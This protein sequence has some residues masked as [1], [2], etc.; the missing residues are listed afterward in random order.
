LVC[1]LRPLK[2]LPTA[3]TALPA[4]LARDFLSFFSFF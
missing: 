1:D 3:V 4:E 2:K